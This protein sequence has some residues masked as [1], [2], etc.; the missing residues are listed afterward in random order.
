MTYPMIDPDLVPIGAAEKKLGTGRNVLYTIERRQR[1]QGMDR[2]FP[3]PRIVGEKVRLWSLT[4][5]EEWWR[6][7]QSA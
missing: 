5:L 7:Q 4:E 3:A 2:G 1:E 6:A